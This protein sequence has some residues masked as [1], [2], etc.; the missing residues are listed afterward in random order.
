MNNSLENQGPRQGANAGIFDI[1][2]L[3]LSKR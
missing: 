1:T 3:H 2:Q